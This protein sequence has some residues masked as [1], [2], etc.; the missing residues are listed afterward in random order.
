[1][2]DEVYWRDGVEVVA[3]IRVLFIKG[4]HISL[5]KIKYINTRTIVTVCF[6]LFF[7]CLLFSCCCCLGGL[8][9]VPCS[10]R[11]SPISL[12]PCHNSKQN[13]M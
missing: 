5:T 7:V 1:M 12:F 13:R 9:L 8:H 6:L 10:P 11:V 3:Y 2:L 4:N